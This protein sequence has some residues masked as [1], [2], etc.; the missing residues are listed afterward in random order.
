[1]KSGWSDHTRTGDGGDYSLNVIPNRIYT[2]S[3]DHSALQSTDNHMRYVR[4][5]YEEDVAVLEQKTLDITVTKS[6][7]NTTIS[8]Y[9]ASP[10]GYITENTVIKFTGWSDTTIDQTAVSDSTGKYT[11]SVAPGNYMVYSH[12]TLY[13]RN[14]VLFGNVSVKRVDGTFQVNLTYLP[15]HLVSGVALLDKTRAALYASV[16]IARSDGS[17]VDIKADDEGKFSVWLPA[18]SYTATASATATEFGMNVTYKLVMNFSVPT[19]P[20]QPLLLH[21]DRDKK[22]GVDMAW[23]NAE[24]Q[25]IPQN[26]TV[27]YTITVRNSG[28]DWDS[29]RLSG[30]PSAWKFEFLGIS[31]NKISLE[32]K[33]RADV[34]VRI[35]PPKDAKVSHDALSVSASSTNSSE[36]KSVN[37]EIGISQTFSV[38]ASADSSQKPEYDG[39]E[40]K[41]GIKVENTGNGDDSYVVSII[42]TDDLKKNGWTATLKYSGEVITR[43]NEIKNVNASAYSSASLDLLVNRTQGKSSPD[44]GVI[45]KVVSSKKG[46][47][48]T[49]VTVKVTCPD[50]TIG[51]GDVVAGGERVQQPKG[52]DWVLTGIYLVAIVIGI[53]AI[54][55]V[56]RKRKKWKKR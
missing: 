23:N 8:G 53:M 43:G 30:I 15:G 51:P 9:L 3:V 27:I 38:K 11:V 29:Y 14:Y 26:S 40:V 18:G 47:T 33:A 52:V 39:N 35:T 28:N 50:L 46:S 25:T 4:Y 54:F 6:L 44:A 5:K 36:T 21:L 16:G 34:S 55:T 17:R 42:N 24:K 20:A 19:P 41:Y 1:M 32:P 48:T 2:I 49:M 7:D 12:G 10:K 31:G 13:G 56:R 22:Y 45:I 37:I